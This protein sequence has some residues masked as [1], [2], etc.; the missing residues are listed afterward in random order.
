M[1]FYVRYNLVSPLNRD[2][3]WKRVT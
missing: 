3:R 2:I 1:I